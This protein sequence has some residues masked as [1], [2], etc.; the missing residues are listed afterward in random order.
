ME[1]RQLRYFIAVADY[2]SVRLA[3]EHLHIT[4]PAVS[5]QI[6]DM[7]AELGFKLFDRSPRGLT[8]TPAG[9]SYL[10]DARK[11]MV[12]LESAASSAQRL[13]VGLAGQL[14]LG[15]VEN[16][17][18]DGLL[19]KLFRKFQSE[20]P[21]VKLEL[22][23]LNSPEQ[24]QGISDGTLDGGFIYQFGSVP[25]EFATMPLL[26]NDVVLAVPHE[27]DMASKNECE[28]IELRS[29]INR[30]FVMFP[31]YVYPSYYDRLIGACQQIGVSLNVVQE[32]TT[33]AAILSLVCAGV[34]AAIVNSAN[35]GRP[36]ALVKFFNLE[37]LSIQMP[38]VFAYR[39]QNNNP[40]L[41]RFI[42]AL[43]HLTG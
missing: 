10:R 39:A 24:L 14:R 34:G 43:E 25:D 20:V 8:L 19:P 15:F 12:L 27:W 29:M 35:R 2:K 26:K 4:Q 16:A 37:D 3:S 30:P 41:A 28:P 9:Q 13:A 40:V 36:P 42:L 23:T 18:W 5:R 32:E 31:R 22:S 33:E 21:A 7:E 6:Q 11:I 38:L 1:L 17:G